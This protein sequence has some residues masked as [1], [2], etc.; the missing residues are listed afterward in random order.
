M[1]DDFQIENVDLI[2][3]A[4]EQQVR[5]RPWLVTPPIKTPS[6]LEATYKGTTYFDIARM[7]T[8]FDDGDKVVAL[9]LKDG[10]MTE[11]TLSG[12]TDND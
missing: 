1:G 6:E 10:R 3:E 4:D 2:E 7:A 8:L 11:I 9:V 12:D 5:Q